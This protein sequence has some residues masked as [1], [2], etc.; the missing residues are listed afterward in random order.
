MKTWRDRLRAWGEF[1]YPEIVWIVIG[2][3]IVFLVLLAQGLT[4][5]HF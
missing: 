5:L 3:V 1:P 2:T 4:W